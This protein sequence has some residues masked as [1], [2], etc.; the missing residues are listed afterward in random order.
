MIVSPSYRGEAAKQQLQGHARVRPAAEEI[1][2]WK[3][4]IEKAPPPLR[5]VER[6]AR[7][8]IAVGRRV[9]R[10]ALDPVQYAQDP[11]AVNR[12]E[13]RTIDGSKN[14]T[15]ATGSLVQVLMH[16]IAARSVKRGD[17]AQ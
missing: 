16:V 12:I 1:P 11:D 9:H 8:F 3:P 14:T 17:I 10:W 5:S 13:I 6:K 7:G 15:I 4:E 2:G